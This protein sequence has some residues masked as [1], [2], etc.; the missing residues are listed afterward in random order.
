MRADE[1]EVNNYPLR[2]HRFHF[3]DRRITA[4]KPFFSQLG[5]CYRSDARQLRAGSHRSTLLETAAF[6]F[7]CPF[8]PERGYRGPGSTWDFQT[9]DRSCRRE[10]PFSLTLDNSSEAVVD[11]NGE[12]HE[13]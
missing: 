2:N 11:V 6:D 7:S 12:V 4:P 13:K 8:I 10:I 3:D 5:Q 9:T 1:N